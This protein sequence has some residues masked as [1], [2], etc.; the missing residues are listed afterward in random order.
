MFRPGMVKIISNVIIRKS[1]P[2]II[3]WQVE[4]K[5]GGKKRLVTKDNSGGLFDV[6]TRVNIV[7]IQS[8]VQGETWGR[9]PGTDPTG[10]ALWICLQNINRTFAE[11]VEDEQPPVDVQPNPAWFVEIDAWARTMGYKGV[12]PFS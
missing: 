3:E 2:Q 4:E 7:E 9:L 1:K 6:G 10:H 5:V 12:F 8:P 11:M